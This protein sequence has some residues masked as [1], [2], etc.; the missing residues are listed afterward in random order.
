MYTKAQL[1]G[2]SSV[3]AQPCQSSRRTPHPLLRGKISENTWLKLS[4]EPIVATLGAFTQHTGGKAGVKF[5]VS[6]GYI[7]MYSEKTKE[8]WLLD[9]F[10]L[11]AWVCV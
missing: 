11:V 8:G 4:V 7:R 9:L 10:T 5:A 6:I 1:T 2:L 3:T